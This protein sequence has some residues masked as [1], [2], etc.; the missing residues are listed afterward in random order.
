MVFYVCMVDRIKTIYWNHNE[1]IYRNL[2]IIELYY[3]N[4]SIFIIYS[5][6]C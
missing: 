2:S 6:N 4:I 3:Y 5:D 1:I